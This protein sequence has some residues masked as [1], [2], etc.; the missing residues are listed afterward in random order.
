M[1]RM[2]PM[3]M[4]NPW[5]GANMNFMPEARYGGDSGSQFLQETYELMDNDGYYQTNGTNQCQ[6]TKGTFLGLGSREQVWAF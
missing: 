5:A 4:Q 6:F 2:P 1:G 3:A